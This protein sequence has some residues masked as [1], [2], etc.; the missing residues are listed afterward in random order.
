MVAKLRA[1]TL[2]NAAQEAEVQGLI[3]RRTPDE[4][5]LPLAP[6]SRTAVRELIAQRCGV[7]PAVRTVGKCLAR[8]GDAL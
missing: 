8:W 7:Q 5:N 6:W 4:L 2:P 3:R 1:A